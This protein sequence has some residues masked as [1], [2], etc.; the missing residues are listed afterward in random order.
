MSG[1]QFFRRKAILERRRRRAARFHAPMGGYILR[2]RGLWEINSG[3][4][5][6]YLRNCAPHMSSFVKAMVLQDM[7]HGLN[8]VADSIMNG[9]AVAMEFGLPT[10][11]DE[12]PTLLGNNLRSGRGASA[13]SD[14]RRMVLFGTA[15]QKSGNAVTRVEIMGGNG[16]YMTT[17]IP[18]RG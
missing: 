4:N 18:H 15:R 7:I 2:Q 14:E 5:M 13:T 1:R 10:F 8:G 16:T 9:L 11:Q 3:P 12:S 6:E 17:A